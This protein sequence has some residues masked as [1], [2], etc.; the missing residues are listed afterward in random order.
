MILFLF[1][2]VFKT[3]KEFPNESFS[4]ERKNFQHKNESRSLLRFVNVNRNFKGNSKND[5]ISKQRLNPCFA[6]A[7]QFIA[8]LNSIISHFDNLNLCITK[9]FTCRKGHLTCLDSNIPQWSRQIA[10]FLLWEFCSIPSG[11]TNGS[12]RS[13]SLSIPGKSVINSKQ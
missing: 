2:F 11:S 12:L 6:V 5:K 7:L 9:A 1:L 13:N 10:I 4:K 3:R 8:G